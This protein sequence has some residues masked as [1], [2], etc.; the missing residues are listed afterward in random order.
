MEV[1]WVLMV[2]Q[3]LTMWVLVDTIKTNKK[4]DMIMVALQLATQGDRKDG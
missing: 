2:S 1:F 4:V 3:V